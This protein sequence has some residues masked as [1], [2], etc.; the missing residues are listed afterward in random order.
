MTVQLKYLCCHVGFIEAHH[1][2]EGFTMTKE[3]KRKKRL[4][5]LQKLDELESKC[6]VN[7]ECK[8]KPG[9]MYFNPETICINCPLYPSFR[10][11]G[12][13]LDG[14]KKRKK[15]EPAKYFTEQE[16]ELIIRYVHEFGKHHGYQTALAKKLNRKAPSIK[17]RLQS[18]E[19][20]GLLDVD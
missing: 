12:E 7:P 9:A 10:E 1:D 20:R 11:I 18:L 13:A 19:K 3:E 14:N 4:E 17:R 2:K 15:Q 6:K 8:Y 16:D 5:L